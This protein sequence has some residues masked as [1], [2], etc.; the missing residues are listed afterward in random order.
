MFTYEEADILVILDKDNKTWYKG[1]DLATILEY[2]KTDDVI[3]KHV[4]KKGR[5]RIVPKLGRQKM[6]PKTIFMN[7]QG[8]FQLI[9]HNKKKEVEKIKCYIIYHQYNFLKNVKKLSLSSRV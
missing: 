4:N 3:N 2:V 9:S 5:I 7:N 1:K 6:D 8:L